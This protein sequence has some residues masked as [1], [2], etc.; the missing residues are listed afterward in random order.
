ML[1][2]HDEMHHHVGKTN[3]YL[4][5]ELSSSLIPF[6]VDT[7]T[8]ALK[9]IGDPVPSVPPGTPLGGTPT[10]GPQRTVAE[11]AISPD[12]RF[13]YVSDRGDS[14]EDHVTI[15][16]RDVKTGAVKWL[17]WVPSGGRN[18]RHFSLSLDKEARYLAVG[19]QDTGNAVI[20]ERDV[21]T[22]DIKRIEGAEYK[23]FPKLAFTGFAPF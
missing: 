2:T 12:G 23:G 21:K 5:C 1:G 20:F 10:G 22:G 4:S 11:V 19:H 15:Y 18:P 13:I 8:G 3:A 9:Q 17:K 16:S 14:E 6:E 7:K